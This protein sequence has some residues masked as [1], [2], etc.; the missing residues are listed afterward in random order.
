MNTGSQLLLTTV[1][2]DVIMPREKVITAEANDAVLVALQK[3]MDN[4][5]SSLPI[6]DLEKYQSIVDTIDI[7]NT[8]MTA[9]SEFDAQKSM[10]DV[11]VSF[12]KALCKDVA[13]KSRLGSTFHPIL[14]TDNLRTAMS[15]MVYLAN[16]HRLPVFDLTGELR[17]ILSQMQLIHILASHLTSFPMVVNKTIGELNLGMNKKVITVAPTQP[18]KDAFNLMKENLISGVGV[19]QNGVLI[20]NVSASDILKIIGSDCSGFG[21]LLATVSEILPSVQGKA[22]PIT[23]TPNNT[24]GDV[25]KVL[26]TEKIH[27]VFIVDSHHKLIGVI[28]PVN[29]L[30]C[31]VDY[32]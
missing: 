23:V 14:D 32:V 25:L 21:K 28:S 15:K 22:K 1:T 16:I 5:I 7:V 2:K 30:E 19:I 3:M 20:G 18:L 29:V 9:F 24:V 26:S 10:E 6:F 17:G 8:A 13:N 12:S 4:K 11:S 31:F 27:R